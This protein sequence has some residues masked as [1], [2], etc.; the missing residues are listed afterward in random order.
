MQLDVLQNSDEKIDLINDFLE[1]EYV[2][3]FKN[4]LEKENNFEKI[5]G[6]MQHEINIEDQVEMREVHKDS[7]TKGQA[8]MDFV[9]NSENPGKTSDILEMFGNELKGC[10]SCKKSNPNLQSKKYVYMKTPLKIAAKNAKMQQRTHVL[11]SAFQ[12]NK[13]TM[14]QGYLG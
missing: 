9:T 1:K 11:T 6:F 12:R 14:Q 7:P 10:E 4:S 3:N 13:H 8:L 2:V 5:N